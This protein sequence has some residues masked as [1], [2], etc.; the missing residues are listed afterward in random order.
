[1]A[2]PAG[3]SEM[4]ERKV[5][6]VRRKEDKRQKRLMDELIERQ[7]LELEELEEQIAADRRRRQEEHDEEMKTMRRNAEAQRRRLWEQNPWVLPPAIYYVQVPMFSHQI[8]L[9]STTVSPEAWK[10]PAEP[11]EVISGSPLED[12]TKVASWVRSEMEGPDLAKTGCA[13]KKERI[14]MNK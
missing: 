2:V 11:D 7:R 4:T 5:A 3:K 1:M 6:D 9:E 8:E 13:K 14:K 12:G 10:T